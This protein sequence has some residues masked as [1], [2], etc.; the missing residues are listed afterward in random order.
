MD[1]GARV[2]LIVTPLCAPSTLDPGTVL[3]MGMESSDTHSP[4]RRGSSRFGMMSMAGSMKYGVWNPPKVLRGY[5]VRI[6]P[7]S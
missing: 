3:P 1:Y 5:L 4:I 7:C 6:S 2:P